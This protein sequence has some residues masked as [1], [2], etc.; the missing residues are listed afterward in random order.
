MPGDRLVKVEDRSR[1][2][3]PARQL[4]MV[5]TGR[6]G[7]AGDNAGIRRPLSGVRGILR[8][9]AVKERCKHGRFGDSR[10]S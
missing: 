1:H 3:R 2:A 8:A 4:D 10:R 6:N 9:V 7:V 5:E